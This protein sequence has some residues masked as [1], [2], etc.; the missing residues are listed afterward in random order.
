MDHLAPSQFWLSGL[1]APIQ[2]HRA[3]LVQEKAARDALASWRA[4][5]PPNIDAMSREALIALA[6]DMSRTIGQLGLLA[7]EESELGRVSINGLAATTAAFAGAAEGY[8]DSPWPGLVMGIGA[9]LGVLVSD[10]PD[11]RA[12]AGSMATSLGAV[13]LYRGAQGLASEVKTRTDRTPSR[14]TGNDA[15]QR[16]SS[17]GTR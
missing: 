10:N 8:L 5:S 17:T 12:A 14:S 13:A 6:Q 4:R 3:R 2:R 9:G 16:P 1:Y 15:S 7:G 11:V